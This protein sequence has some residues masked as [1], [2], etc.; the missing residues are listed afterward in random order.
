M[1]TLSPGRPQDVPPAQLSSR[2]LLQLLLTYIK[3][4]KGAEE[5]LNDAKR[6]RFEAGFPGLKIPTGRFH[7]NDDVIPSAFPADP[8]VL[9]FH[10]HE[11]HPGR[12]R[13][14]QELQTA[15]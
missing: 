6:A 15:H 1:G 4:S 2:L 10:L 9:R 5:C 7:P 12:R 13:R 14:S 3:A 8:D 11:L